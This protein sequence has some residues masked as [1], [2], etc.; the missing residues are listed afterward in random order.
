MLNFGIDRPENYYETL[1]L[2]S[3]QASEEDIEVRYQELSKKHNPAYNVDPENIVKFKKIQGAYECLKTYACRVQ[4]NKF[5]SY[6]ST[7]V[8]NTETKNKGE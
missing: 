3:S 7:L 8:V 4:Y 2:R 1:G 5:G 6:I